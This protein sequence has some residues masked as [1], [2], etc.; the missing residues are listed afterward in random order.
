MAKSKGDL[1]EAVVVTT[2]P[3]IVAVLLKEATEGLKSYFKDRRAKKAE[4]N[5]I[6]IK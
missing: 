3:V 1:L 5:G 4:S 6:E 2:V